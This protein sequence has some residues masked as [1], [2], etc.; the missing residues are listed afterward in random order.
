MD[1]VQADQAAYQGDKI[2][3]AEHRFEQRR[4][5]RHLRV[6]NDVAVTDGRQCPKTEIAHFHK[7]LFFDLRKQRVRESNPC[8]S[9][10]R[11]VS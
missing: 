6:R 3:L 5:P 10:E 1:D 4:R 8:T 9:L 7:G 2:K 11:A